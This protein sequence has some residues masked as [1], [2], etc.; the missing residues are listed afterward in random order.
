MEV[1]NIFVLQGLRFI[2]NGLNWNLNC[3]KGFWQEEKKVNLLGKSGLKD[4]LWKYFY[5]F[6]LIQK[7]LILYFPMDGFMDF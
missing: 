2:V 5:Q 7:D 3:M 4:I 6:I 1:I